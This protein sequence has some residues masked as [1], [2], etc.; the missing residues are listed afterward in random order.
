MAKTPTAGNTMNLGING[1]LNL[2]KILTDL[3]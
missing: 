3:R 2:N 1:K